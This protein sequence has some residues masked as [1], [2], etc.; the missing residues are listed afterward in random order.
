LIALV[1]LILSSVS[2]SQNGDPAID[3]N[4]FK[5]IKLQPVVTDTGLHFT[6]I[7]AK[8]I[9]S[10]LI[11][12][13]QIK[14]NNIYLSRLYTESKVSSSKQKLIIEQDSIQK[15]KLHQNYMLVVEKNT[16]LKKEI[17]R[18]NFIITASL[19]GT[20]TLTAILAIQTIKK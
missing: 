3:T 12:H 19:I 8:Y 6:N 11:K 17:T 4:Y 15:V 9:Y 16:F 14:K 5:I 10:F 2:Y 1:F 18:K 13:N 7:E 20:A